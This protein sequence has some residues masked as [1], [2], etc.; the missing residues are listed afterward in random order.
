ME[1]EG[2][3]QVISKSF[4]N[5]AENN[6]FTNILQFFMQLLIVVLLFFIIYFLV[7]IGNQYIDTKN[8]INIG[9]RQIV[10]FILLL[11]CL[12]FIIVLFQA[13]SLMYEMLSPFLFAII[14]AY[15]LN[16]LVSYIE[17]KGIKRL[18]SIFIVYFLIAAIIFIF[19]ITLVPKI[20]SE[21]K[22]L[23]DTLPQL[24]N[25]GYEYIYN[26]YV[27]YNNNIENLPEEL[28][29][30]KDL[31]KFDVNK[32]ENVIFKTMSSVTNSML[33]IVSKIVNL[34]LTPILAFYFL[35]DSTKFKNMLILAIP[36]F[37]RKGIINVAKD[38]D[39]VLGGFIRGQLIVA[40]IV[41]ILTTIS[42]LI[43]RVEFAVLVGMIAGIFNIIPYFGPIV[44][45]IPAAIFA[46]LGGLNKVIWVIVIFTIIQQIESSVIS[47][48]IISD[49]VGI[50]PVVVILSLIVGGKF[51][52][53]FGLL[54]AVPIAGIIKVIGKHFINYIAKF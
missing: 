34:V 32:L 3:I 19:S 25:E 12:V 18:W 42:L 33:S 43:L 4:K 14:L 41:G 52:G 1:S 8:R 48:K 5:L 22:K 6:G 31:L 9:K 30:V 39:E 35:K 49:K 29:G 37:S 2:T 26:K 24:G 50:H 54:I 11:I 47:P 46:S 36:K 38:I 13:G 10:Y 21:T 51:F 7:H 20:T 40:G 27:K 16:P 44:G 15:T 45:I 17:K 23:L 53:L 28:R